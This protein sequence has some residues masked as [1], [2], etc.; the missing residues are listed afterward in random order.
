LDDIAD[1]TAADGDGASDGVEDDALA[2]DG[3]SDGAAAG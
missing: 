3:E 1:G 2:E